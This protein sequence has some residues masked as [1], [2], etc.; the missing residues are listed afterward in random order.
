MQNTKVDQ[1]KDGVT[2]PEG[3]IIFIA[4][5]RNIL[6][7]Y[8][9][10]EICSLVIRS[11]KVIQLWIHVVITRDKSLLRLCLFFIERCFI[12]QR[13]SSNLIS[14]VDRS[15]PSLPIFF[16]TTVRVFFTIFTSYSRLFYILLW[17][18][19]PALDVVLA[20]ILYYLLFSLFYFLSFPLLAFLFSS[21]TVPILL[22]ELE[23]NE[24]SSSSS[25]NS[26]L[27]FHTLFFAIHICRVYVGWFILIL[28]Y[29][30]I[31]RF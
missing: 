31:T 2:N 7:R 26:S 10:Y 30:E 27:L 1:L 5:D 29:L 18:R 17:L 19:L 8:T 4:K 11:C 12:A 20:N 25:L 21:M 24:I 6:S 15:L 23:E 16:V 14:S 9:L 28:T 13:I 3:L 22:K